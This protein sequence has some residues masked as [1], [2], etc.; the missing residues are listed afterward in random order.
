M[1]A[2]GVLEGIEVDRERL[3][4]EIEFVRTVDRL[5]KV[6]RQSQ[7]M[8]GGRRENSAEHSWHLAVMVLV[9]SRHAERKINVMKTVRMALVH[10]IPEVYAG[11]IFVYHD[12]KKKRKAARE[13]RA[14]R[15]LFG[16]LPR[17]QGGEL[18]RLWREYEAGKSPEARFL[19]ALD[20]LGPLMANYHTRGYAWRRNRVRAHSV[21]SLNSAWGKHA[22]QLGR[23]AENMIRGAIAKGFLKK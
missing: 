3:E 22:R 8:S 18:F 4:R 1:A 6:L 17:A 21:L 15:R 9:L 5:K 23:Y 19:Y 12:A 14:A 16:L 13:R 20:R 2:K 11:D 7:I 10:D